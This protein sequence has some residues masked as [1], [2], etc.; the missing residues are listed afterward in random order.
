[1]NRLKYFALD[2]KWLLMGCCLMAIASECFTIQGRMDQAAR[3]TWQAAMET[4]EEET[5]LDAC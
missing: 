5:P 2:N 1:M 3:D 4:I